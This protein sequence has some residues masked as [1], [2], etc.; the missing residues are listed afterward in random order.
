MDEIAAAR[1]SLVAKVELAEASPSLSV[2]Y[3]SPVYPLK[4]AMATVISA[5]LGRVLSP[6]HWVTAVLS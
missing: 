6:L 4:H 3:P 1:I 2:L 5:L